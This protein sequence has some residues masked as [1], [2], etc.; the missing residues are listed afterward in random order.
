[1]YETYPKPSG[2]GHEGSKAGWGKGNGTRYPNPGLP[3][4]KDDTGTVNLKEQRGNGQSPP[5]PS[6]PK[7]PLP[8][9]P[10]LNGLK[11]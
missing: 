2:Q 10:K 6:Y 7:K 5:A 11:S 1:M 8:S 4:A 3:S 9:F